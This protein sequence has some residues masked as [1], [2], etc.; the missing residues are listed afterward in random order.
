MAIIR[1]S[2]IEVVNTKKLKKE[3][4]S[5]VMIASK[6]ALSH[7]VRFSLD[8]ASL[9]HQETPQYIAAIINGPWHNDQCYRVEKADSDMGLSGSDQGEVE[10]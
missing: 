6:S 10:G 4:R 8:N 7:C 2:V 9:T 5:E 1:G 3:L